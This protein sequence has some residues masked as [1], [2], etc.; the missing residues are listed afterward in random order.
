MSRKIAVGIDIGTYQVKAV[1]AE[2]AENEEGKNGPALKV[3]GTGLTESRGQR[4]GYI[5]NQSDVIKSIK[6][7]VAQAEKSSGM[8]IKRAYLSIGGVGLS[9]V[10]S[11]GSVV[12]SRADLEI[13]DLDLKKALEVAETEIPS[14]YSLN[15]K[16][17]HTVPIQFK[18]DGKV[19]LGNPLRMKGARLEAK[20]L[21]I[22]CLEQHLSDLVEAANEAGIEVLDVMAS[23]IAASLVSL[24][25]TQKIAGCVLAN[26]GAETVS[27]V[28]Y[29]NNKP[30]S[31]EVFPIGSTDITNDIALGLKI[32]IEEAEQIKLGGITTT[33][34]PR[35][36]LEEI[37]D[38]RLSDMFE[39]IEAHLKK[40]GRNGLLPA[41]II[42]T[43]GG[44]GMTSLED[45]ARNSLKLPSRIGFLQQPEN[46]KS[47]IK[48]SSWSVACGL[49]L[50]GFSADGESSSGFVKISNSGKGLARW[51]KEFFRQFLP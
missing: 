32:P 22:S 19:V 45:F 3:L 10:T 16:I 20:V 25:K 43:G 12:I 50:F 28:V 26:I 33:T 15:R 44:S 1:I 4:H 41:G 30:I 9:A 38:A 27:I 8:K 21:F 5:I 29:E 24:S 35:K 47:A 40:I 7:A 39:L 6:S 42:I 14:S 46:A 13:T 2:K 36:K 11:T 34:F 18:I 17:I 31:L 23:P 49:C 51:A 37:V 48:D